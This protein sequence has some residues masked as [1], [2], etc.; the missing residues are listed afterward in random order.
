MPATGA[1]AE[2]FDAVG[3]AVVVALAGEESV[4]E[5]L[6]CIVEGGPWSAVVGGGRGAGVV[7]VSDDE[8]EVRDGLFTEGLVVGTRRVRV[9]RSPPPKMSLVK[10]LTPDPMVSKTSEYSDCI[11]AARLL[12]NAEASMSS[13]FVVTGPSSAVAVCMSVADA[14]FDP[15]SA[16]TWPIAVSRP[17]KASAVVVAPVMFACSDSRF[18]VLL[19]IVELLNACAARA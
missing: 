15:E 7:V 2:G 12:G 5:G 6:V 3:A 14:G 4:S 1:L 9:V 19:R 18:I 13:T 8:V 16:P 10:L 17:P 11:G